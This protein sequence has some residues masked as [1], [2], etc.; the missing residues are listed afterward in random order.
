[1]SITGSDAGAPHHFL[2]RI[3]AEGWGEG[4]P[5]VCRRA[6]HPHPTSLTEGE[7]IASESASQN[8]DEST[9]MPS[10]VALGRLFLWQSYVVGYDPA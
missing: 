6:G 9:V 1:M 5:A 8:G 3:L 4:I 2:P 7:G 10:N